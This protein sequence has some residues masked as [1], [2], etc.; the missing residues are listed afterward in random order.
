MESHC[1]PA[2]F[3][4]SPDCKLSGGFLCRLMLRQ[5]GCVPR[6]RVT[7]HARSVR[8]LSGLLRGR[9]GFRARHG[10]GD[11]LHRDGGPRWSPGG[12][13]R[14]ELPWVVAGRV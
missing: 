7:R 2:S 3:T 9:T 10:R 14:N 12:K 6:N 4:G 8:F 1:A 11:G 13:E 5:A